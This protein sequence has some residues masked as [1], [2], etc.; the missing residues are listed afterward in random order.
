MAAPL[1]ALTQRM[2]TN[3]DAQEELNIQQAILATTFSGTGTEVEVLGTRLLTLGTETL[4]R[5]LGGFRIFVRSI[6][7]LGLR[8]IFQN[9]ISYENLLEEDRQAL[10]KQTAER[11]K[12]ADEQTEIQRKQ[13]EEARKAAAAT[14]ALNK[15]I[16]EEKAANDKAAKDAQKKIDDAA[17][18]KAKADAKALQDAAR[19]QAK[20][21]ANITKLQQQNAQTTGQAL[22]QTLADLSEFNRQQQALRDKATGDIGNLVGTKEQIEAQ[23]ALIETALANQIKI[24]EQKRDE[25][26]AIVDNKA[27]DDSIQ[28][29]ENTS[30]EQTTTANQEFIRTTSGATADEIIAAEKI[31]Q[32]ELTRI[33]LEE[34]EKRRVIVNESTLLTDEQKIQRLRDLSDRELA[35]NEEKNQAILDANQSAL[36]KQAEQQEQLQEIYL[37]AFDGIGEGLS[38]FFSDQED[39]GKAFLKAILTTAV[40]ALEKF[41]LIQIATATARE[42]GTKGFIGIATGAVLA[43]LIK[44]L[45][46]GIRSQIQSFEEGGKIDKNKLTD[47]AVAAYYDRGGRTKFPAITGGRIIGPSHEDGGVKFRVGNKIGEARGNEVISN[48][49]QLAR[50]AALFGSDFMQR[51]GVPDVGLINPNRAS[52]FVPQVYRSAGAT[53][54]TT[55]NNGIDIQQLEQMAA[56]NAAQQTKVLQS[57]Q[58]IIVDSVVDALQEG[59]RKR[60]RN[61]ATRNANTF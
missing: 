60:N 53:S 23:T 3:I 50:G 25:A 59:K 18:A 4:N 46:A 44:G 47:I 33:E 54:V 38:A 31:L 40:E 51:M 1:D 41:L 21:T 24:L 56:I 36:D 29:T 11:Q 32:A 28:A 61:T 14:R 15:K 35:I 34:I 17:K 55:N 19:D 12:A 16:K 37:S 8:G 43:G 27:F 10:E 5:V 42:I 13:A 9:S 7:E 48:E 26:Q 6:K 2:Q 49:Q 58:A 39:A 57:M 20:A 45:G 52:N 30:A 22:G